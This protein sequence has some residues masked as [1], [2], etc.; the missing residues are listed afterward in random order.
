[1]KRALSILLTVIV[2]VSCNE[3]SDPDSGLSPKVHDIDEPAQLELNATTKVD[4]SDTLSH[5]VEPVSKDVKQD[6]VDLSG[7]TTVKTTQYEVE[8]LDTL[9]R[10]QIDSLIRFEKKCLG[11]SGIGLHWTFIKMAENKYELTAHTD[12]GGTYQGYTIIDNSLVFLMPDEPLLYYKTN[13]KKDFVFENKKFP[14][15]EDY[16]VWIF[17]FEDRV[18]TIL[19]SYTLPCD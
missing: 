15:A 8:L 18:L 7:T 1:M 12:F 17:E 4:S 19:K 3:R 5:K 14:Y 6:I 16:S 10:N 13:R 2:A 9:F 11:S